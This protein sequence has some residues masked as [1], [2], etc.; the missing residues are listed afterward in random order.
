MLL[1]LSS[2]TCPQL[3]FL[4]HLLW[5]S[6]YLHWNVN[7][8]TAGPVA[9]FI[10]LQ[11]T[12]HRFCCDTS[13]SLCVEAASLH[14][15]ERKVYQDWFCPI[16]YNA[17]NAWGTHGMGSSQWG[18]EMGQDGAL[19]AGHMNHMVKN[20]TEA[21]QFHWLFLLRK[22]ESPLAGF[23]RCDQQH[24][25]FWAKIHILVSST[26]IAKQNCWGPMWCF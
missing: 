17:H 19:S 10:P 13:T 16:K 3:S 24:P 2:I 1:F 20:Q 21:T 23:S 26:Y 25:N 4:M 18:D 14:A 12:I 15:S 11:R 22:W 9:F 7:W 8:Q 5:V 6:S